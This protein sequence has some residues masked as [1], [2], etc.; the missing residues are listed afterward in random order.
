M[1]SLREA[2]EAANFSDDIRESVNAL[3]EHIEGCYRFEFETQPSNSEVLRTLAMAIPYPYLPADQANAA[4]H[5]AWG[6]L[7]TA[8]YL[9]ADQDNL[10]NLGI[11]FQPSEFEKA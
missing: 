1:I 10:K 3:F 5:T 8:A 6:W 2:A 9:D 4:I 11:D 7:I